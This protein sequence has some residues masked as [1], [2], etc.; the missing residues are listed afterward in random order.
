MRPC[1]GD[2][3]AA[4]LLRRQPVVVCMRSKSRWLCFMRPCSG[5][6]IGKIHDS[7]RDAGHDDPHSQ[8]VTQLLGDLFEFRVASLFSLP[9]VPRV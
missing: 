3:A 7:Q 4:R 1:P 5:L 9:L 6:L 8:R 2:Y